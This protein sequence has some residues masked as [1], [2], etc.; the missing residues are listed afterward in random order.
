MIQQRYLEK[1]H[2]LESMLRQ[3][4]PTT[5]VD[6][7]MS[8]L[9]EP[10]TNMEELLQKHAREREQDL[11]VDP[12]VTTMIPPNSSG[13]RV[14]PYE[15]VEQRQTSIGSPLPRSIRNENNQN[16]QQTNVTT[17][18]AFTEHKYDTNNINLPVVVSTNNIRINISDEPVAISI[19]D[20]VS[21]QTHPVIKKTSALKKHISFQEDRI[22]NEGIRNDPLPN[23][24]GSESTFE[25]SN[26]EANVPRSPLPQTTLELS[27]QIPEYVLL[28]QKILKLEQEMAVLKKLFFATFKGMSV[29][30][31]Q[32]L[33]LE[34]S[35]IEIS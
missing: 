19:I 17:I 6:F 34:T 10:I 32:T 22:E 4:N 9:D 15:L 18:N 16:S 3:P 35:D 13:E 29:C 31:L 14:S 33:L 30:H 1:Q 2:E 23:S 12:R 25:V 11:A 28:E 26:E 20:L 7:K 24:S 27:Y 21:D 8:T 5:P